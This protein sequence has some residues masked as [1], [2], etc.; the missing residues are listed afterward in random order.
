MS[1][2]ETL[3]FTLQESGRDSSSAYSLGNYTITGSGT[4]SASISQLQNDLDATYTTT[5]GTSHRQLHIDRDWERRDGDV[6]ARLQ[7]PTARPCKARRMT[8][9]GSFKS[10]PHPPIPTRSRRRETTVATSPFTRTDSIT[11]T[12]QIER[13]LQRR[14]LFQ[15]EDRDQQFHSDRNGSLQH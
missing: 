2:T 13:R 6:R 10:L 4:V 14:H 8:S 9:A 15:H 5:S 12:I 11:S 3:S 1:A 7:A